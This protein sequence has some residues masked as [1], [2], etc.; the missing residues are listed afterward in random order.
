MMYTHMNLEE[1]RQWLEKQ[2][3]IDRLPEPIWTKLRDRH[4][5][6]ENLDEHEL[7]D[8][9]NE[10]RDF[11]DV[12]RAAS[13]LPTATTKGRHPAI[14]PGE[15]GQ[16]IDVELGEYERQRKRAA[17]KV[18][19][20]Y[21]GLHEDARGN[22][23]VADF[24]QKWLDGHLLSPEQAREFLREPSEAS[25]A[26]NDLAL[27]W[28]KFYGWEQED[29]AWT[30]LTGEAPQLD[31]LDVRVLYH[32]LRPFRIVMTAEHWLPAEVV[33]RNFRETQR[34]LLGGDRRRPSARSLAVLEFVED[35]IQSE[36]ERPSWRELLRRWNAQCPEWAY[37]D[38]AN[39]Y[40]VYH[41]A[42]EKV[43]H[44]SVGL[45]RRKPSPAEQRRRQRQ[46]EE[47]RAAEARLI[48]MLK[49]HSEQ[50]ATSRS[51]P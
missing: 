39:F 14:D 34:R 16:N 28:A 32:A 12:Y 42:L 37:K 36:G 29:M 49:T 27:R 23:V 9:V 2:L 48:R 44:P 15:G 13:G 33:E 46:A 35:Q 45:I 17:T 51:D 30:I 41:R 6:R 10:A 4:Y 8:L 20:R 26:L 1:L 11:L 5:A 24:R 40:R 38:A 7:A 25:E 3:R 19:A 22:K 50:Q 47:A 21:V 43:A 18:L 31:P